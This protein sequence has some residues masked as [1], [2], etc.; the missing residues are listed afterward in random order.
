MEGGG[1]RGGRGLL[2]AVALAP[3]AEA[4]EVVG[5]QTI[6]PQLE[7]LTVRTAALARRHTRSRPLAL[8]VRPL[9]GAALA[10]RLRA[11]RRPGRPHVVVEGSDGVRVRDLPA[12]DRRHAR[13]RSQRLLQRLVQRRRRRPAGM[14]EL[15]RRRA[16]TADR[17]PLPD[18]RRPWRAHPLGR[19][20]G[21]FRCL[22]LRGSPPRPVRRRNQHLRGARHQLPDRP[23]A[24]HQ[25]PHSRRPSRPTRCSAPRETQEIRWRASNPW[26][27]AAN[28]RSLDLQ[29]RTHSGR[30]GP[31]YL[32]FDGIEYAIHEMS[33]SLHR[34]LDELSIPHLWRDYGPGDHSGATARFP[35]ADSLETIAPVAERISVAAGDAE[36]IRPRR[37]RAGVLRL[38]LD[39]RGR[40]EAGARVPARQRRWSQ[41]RDARGV[42]QGEGYDGTAVPEVQEGRRDE[43]GRRRGG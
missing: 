30:P 18:A 19:L 23:G 7:E 13:R 20:D 11:A 3:R 40:P 37:R 26:D 34:R 41:G 9:P 5:A 6:R 10:G 1:A 42:G 31:G 16:S 25:R 35:I 14:G 29:I 24:R 28:L 8:R 22:Q 43:R 36:V 33:E 39:V 27:L 32:G 12:G 4:A 15:S 21:R 17:R 38:G 2:V